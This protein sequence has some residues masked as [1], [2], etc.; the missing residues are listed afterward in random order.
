M[1]SPRPTDLNFAL[2]PGLAPTVRPVPAPMAQ[3]PAVRV[4]AAPA[5]TIAKAPAT[6][7]AVR[8][9]PAKVPAVRKA[10]AKAPVL[11]EVSTP[12]TEP[13]VRPARAPR[14][15]RAKTATAEQPGTQ[16]RRRIVQEAET[17]RVLEDAARTAADMLAAARTTAT[18][19]TADIEEETARR[20]QEMVAATTELADFLEDLADR[21]RTNGVLSPR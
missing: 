6:V 19:L 14:T 4:V 16:T 7:P 5:P 11:H 9:A 8:K 21:L 3:L 17:G 15:P 10:P 1:T 20:R 13:A 2:L 12:V 18:R